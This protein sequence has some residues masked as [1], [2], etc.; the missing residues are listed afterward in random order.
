MK[1]TRFALHGMTAAIALMISASVRSTEPKI[2]GLFIGDGYDDAGGGGDPVAANVDGALSADPAP[3]AEG[4]G[5]KV[6]STEEGAASVV[7][8]GG[9]APGAVVEGAADPA[10]G[11]EGGDKA[12]DA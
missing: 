5:E 12:A 9:P 11:G 2:R 4:G 6:A 3:G 1:K 10:G 7:E 8:E